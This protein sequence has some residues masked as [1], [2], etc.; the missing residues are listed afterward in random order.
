[1]VDLLARNRAQLC[2]EVLDRVSA[3]ICGVAKDSVDHSRVHRH[4]YSLR[5]PRK[6]RATIVTK[7]K[8]GN[9]K[10]KRGGSWL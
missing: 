5:P 4:R 1:M 6:N 8:N 3:E 2:N 10:K 9:I 7:K